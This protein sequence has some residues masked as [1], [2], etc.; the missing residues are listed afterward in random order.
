M[1]VAVVVVASWLITQY[2][3]RVIDGTETRLLQVSSLVEFQLI[4]CDI[5]GCQRTFIL[6]VW[7]TSTA[8]WGATH[9]T[10]NY[11]AFTVVTWDDATGIRV[12][13]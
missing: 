4:D 6:N 12:Q 2:I 7:E 8:D 9:N 11:Q 10:V 13:N 3:S 1:F 5:N